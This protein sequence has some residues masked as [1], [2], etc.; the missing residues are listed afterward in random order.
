LQTAAVLGALAQDNCNPS[1][2]PRYAPRK[3]EVSE[4]PTT[5]VIWPCFGLASRAR[6]AV[7]AILGNIHSWVVW[8]SLYL[9]GIMTQNWSLEDFSEGPLARGAD[10]DFWDPILHTPVPTSQTSSVVDEVFRFFPNP[11]LRDPI[12]MLTEGPSYWAPDDFDGTENR[13]VNVSDPWEA[14]LWPASSGSA[15]AVGNLDFWDPAPISAQIEIPNVIEEWSDTIPLPQYNPFASERP[16]SRFFQQTRESLA[17]KRARWILSILGFLNPFRQRFIFGAFTDLFIE[18]PHHSTFRALSDLALDDTSADELVNA[19]ALKQIWSDFPLF[20]SFRTK[21]RDVL[22]AS[23]KDSLLGWTLAV[24]LI[25]QS[26]GTPP[27]KLIDPDWFHEWLAV[28]YADPLYWRFID[29]IRARVEAV[30]SGAL[31]TP[32][33]LRQFVLPLKEIGIDGFSPFNN[34]SRTSLLMRSHT[35]RMEFSFSDQSTT[36]NHKR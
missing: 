28:P 26:R 32:P 4:L 7:D 34:F 2:T 19:F 9:L 13:A 8:G 27:E 14:P 15:N 24:R 22:V 33:T 10:E 36:Y 29:Y 3:E 25:R 30:D 21:R 35:D 23:N 16:F 5:F 11:P 20:S 18:Y 31:E 1:E 17:E 6:G 12:E